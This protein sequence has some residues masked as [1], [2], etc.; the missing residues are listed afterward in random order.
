MQPYMEHGL[1]FLW[2]Y[3]MIRIEK[4]L[5]QSKKEKREYI[6]NTYSQYGRLY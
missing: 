5:H 2:F 3:D 6:A 4:M 1:S